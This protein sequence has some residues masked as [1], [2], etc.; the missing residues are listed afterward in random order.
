MPKEKKQTG[1]KNDQDASVDVKSQG[2]KDRVDICELRNVRPPGLLVYPREVN[3]YESD[4]AVVGHCVENW[5]LVF[6]RGFVVEGIC[7][8]ELFPKL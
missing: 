4:V 6:V 7:P 3:L 8:L 2:S 5:M 1:G